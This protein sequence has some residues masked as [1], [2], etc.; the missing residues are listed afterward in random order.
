VPNPIPLEN[1]EVLPVVTSDGYGYGEEAFEP[2]G[3]P[4][5]PDKREPVHAGSAADEE[6][7]EGALP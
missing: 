7:P 5:Q 3:E 2:I 4:S 6:S 1:F